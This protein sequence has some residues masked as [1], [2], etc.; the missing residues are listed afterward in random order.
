MS[1]CLERKRIAF[2][3]GVS[4]IGFPSSTLGMP[5]MLRSGLKAAFRADHVRLHPTRTEY[6]RADSP[7]LRTPTFEECYRAGASP[8]PKVC[9]N[10]MFFVSLGLA[11]SEKQIPQITENTEKSK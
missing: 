6:Q 9:Q 5:A 10:P 11:L 4:S 1:A 8:V 2:L 3:R 7:W